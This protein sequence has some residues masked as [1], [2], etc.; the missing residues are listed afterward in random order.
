MPVLSI[1]FYWNTAVLP[2]LHI[3]RGRHQSGTLRTQTIWPN[4]KKSLKYLVSDPS[5]KM[6]PTSAPRRCSF[7]FC[8]LFSP[9]RKIREKWIWDIWNSQILT[10]VL[11][12]LI[13]TE[14]MK[15]KKKR[16]LQKNPPKH[17]CGGYNSPYSFFRLPNNI[18]L[19]DEQ[20]VMGKNNNNKKQSAL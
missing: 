4:K 14:A 19:L 17:L 1:K 3:L 6:L 7:L 12:L 2:C 8:L 5:R 15:K 10:I 18:L 11:F 9:F 16:K 13:F 20:T